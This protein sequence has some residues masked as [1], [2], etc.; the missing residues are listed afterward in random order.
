[1]TTSHSD[2]LRQQIA[3]CLD[4][5]RAGAALHLAGN[6]V[7]D[8][9]EETYGDKTWRCLYGEYR[10]VTGLEMPLNFSVVANHFGCTEAEAQYLFGAAGVPLI[11]RR[12]MVDAHL[13]ELRAKLALAELAELAVA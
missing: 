5:R 2:L 7:F 12:M 8:T 9:V 11:H 4:L 10:H 1:M 3:R 6:V 13:E